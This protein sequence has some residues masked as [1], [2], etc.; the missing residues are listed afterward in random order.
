MATHNCWTDANWFFPALSLAALASDPT[1]IVK[2]V[3][4]EVHAGQPVYHL[5]LF[6]NLSGQAPEVIAFVQQVSAL[7]LYLD[8]STLLPAAIAFSIRADGNS[9]VSIPVEIQFASYQAVSGVRVAF[10]IQK[11]LQGTLTLD[12]TITN[13]AINSGVPASVFTLPYVP[14]GGAQ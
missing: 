6:H 3:G 12:L 13:A 7:D 14:A 4:Q 5:L 2:L 1:A 9:A 8:A 11:L 10:R